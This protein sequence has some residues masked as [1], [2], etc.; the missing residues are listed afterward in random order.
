MR[1]SSAVPGLLRV[2]Q[3]H[4]VKTRVWNEAEWLAS[5]ETYEDL[6][7]RSDADRLFLSWDWLTLWWQTLPRR[8]GESLR[9]HAAYDGELLVGALVTAVG[10][11]SR[12]GL[13]LGSVQLLGSRFRESRGAFSEYLDVVATPALKPD[14][15]SACIR[16]AMGGGSATEFVVGVTRDPQGWR[17]ALRRTTPA[18]RGYA[19]LVDSMTSY[20][21]DLSC[22]FPEYLAS[23]SGNARRSLFNLRKKLASKGELRFVDIPGEDC[24]ASLD[25]LNALHQ[26]RWGK[27][28]LGGET[29]RLHQGLID[30]WAP[31]DRIRMSQ[32]LLDGRVVSLLY[33]IRVGTVQYNI[34]MAFDP[35]I[36]RSLSIGLLH[37]GYSMEQAAS[38]GVRT[39]DFLAGTGRSTDYKKRI[40][41]RQCGVATVQFLSRPLPAAMFRL[42]DRLRGHSRQA[43]AQGEDAPSGTEDS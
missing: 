34:Q 39:Y 43:S 29:L 15:R 38:Q 40:A 1:T 14:I 10:P 9:V 2:E 21:A 22:G 33:D 27:P 28:A 41:S 6:L 36:D 11:A 16:S 12:K 31:L 25:Q 4:T 24:A 3:Q 17:D 5:R 20:Q 8:D 32:L 23:L 26:L 19:R 42:H 13:R 7:A 18:W 37:L 30:R 35:D